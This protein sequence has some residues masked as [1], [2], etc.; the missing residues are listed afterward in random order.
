MLICLNKDGLFDDNRPS[1]L[2]HEV[3]VNDKASKVNRADSFI[4]GDDGQN[5]QRIQKD[6]A[7]KQQK[8]TPVTDHTRMPTD[9]APEDFK[10]DI[11]DTDPLSAPTNGGKKKGKKGA[12]NQSKFIVLT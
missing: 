5:N 9:T 1:A 4:G 6:L 11:H 2:E 10:S 12:K 7:L 3:R 8:S